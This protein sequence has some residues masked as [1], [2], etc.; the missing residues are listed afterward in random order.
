LSKAQV[1]PCQPGN[2]KNYC[3]GCN[4]AIRQARQT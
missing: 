1:F 4:R 2:S 3:G